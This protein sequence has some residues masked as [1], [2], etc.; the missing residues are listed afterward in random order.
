MTTLA[1]AAGAVSQ[2]RRFTVAPPSPPPPPTTTRSSYPN[3]SGSSSAASSHERGRNNRPKSTPTA[4]TAADTG[5]RTSITALP[6]IGTCL[7]KLP[8][9][10]PED[11]QPLIAHN[12]SPRSDEGIR[13]SMVCFMTFFLVYFVSYA[14]ADVLLSFFV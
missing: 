6:T 9:L 10:S 3:T 5:T 4:T 11:A 13:E 12:S 8:Y 7:H 2:S 1:F 14:H